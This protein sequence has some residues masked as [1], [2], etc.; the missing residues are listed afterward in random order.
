M[1][2][3]YNEQSA[4]IA[5]LQ[6]RVR[7]ADAEIDAMKAVL[8]DHD[9]RLQRLNA[10]ILALVDAGQALQV[11]YDFDAHVESALD[12]VAEHDGERYTVRKL[13]EV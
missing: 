11:E 2:R 6:E 5:A 9:Q 12:T 1:T 13:D 4:M 10:F 8:C 7:V 3:H